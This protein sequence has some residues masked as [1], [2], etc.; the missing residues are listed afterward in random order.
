MNDALSNLLQRID[1]KQERVAARR[2]LPPEVV[3]NLRE[4]LGVEWTYE[5]NAIEGNSLT[6]AE[7]RVVVLD[8]LTIGGKSVREHLEATNHWAALQHL[9]TMTQAGPLSEDDVLT[10]HGLILRG[11]DD[12]NA[13]RYRRVQVEISGSRHLPPPPGAVPGR[14]RE[15]LQWANSEAAEARHPVL[16]AAEFHQRLVD[17]HPFVDGNGRTARLALNLILLRAGYVP[18]IIPTARRAEYIASI[19]AW[20]RKEAEPFER[21]VAEEEERTLDRYLRALS[22]GQFGDR[23]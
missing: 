4:V 5:S 19:E 3:A 15:L 20:R 8:G 9:E 23:E 16:R 22:G 18:A 21:L 11:L 2:P 13:G 10:L 12:R 1:E 14:M 7:T 6:L 17:I